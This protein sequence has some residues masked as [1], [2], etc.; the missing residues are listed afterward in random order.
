MACVPIY[1]LFR[2]PEMCGIQMV[3]CSDWFH[4]DCVKITPDQLKTKS[5]PWYCNN[6]IH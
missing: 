5:I 3:N 2:M 1:C 6:C 4:V